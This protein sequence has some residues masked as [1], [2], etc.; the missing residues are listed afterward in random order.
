MSKMLGLGG[1]GLVGGV[2]TRGGLVTAASVSTVPVVSLVRRGS[3]GSGSGVSS[4]GV[5]AS[6]GISSR[7][8]GYSLV[9]VMSGFAWGGASKVLCKGVAPSVASVM[10]MD[11]ESEACVGVRV[12]SGGAATTGSLGGVG[13]G[14]LENCLGVPLFPG[15]QSERLMCL[16]LVGDFQFGCAVFF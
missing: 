4:I 7:C 16:E 10:G 9:A 2:E 12:L 5:V 14:P 8:A 15:S 11:P 13:P 1:V 6:S 3:E